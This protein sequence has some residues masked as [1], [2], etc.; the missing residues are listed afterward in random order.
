MAYL[1]IISFKKH[2]LSE[3]K[4]ESRKA[5]KYAQTKKKISTNFFACGSSGNEKLSSIFWVHSKL[6]EEL[7]DDG[8]NIHLSI[9]L[10]IS[11]ASSL[12]RKVEVDV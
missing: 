1:F 7:C 3:M 6:C 11:I 12:K 2:P 8:V 10:L 5:E 9:K 4:S